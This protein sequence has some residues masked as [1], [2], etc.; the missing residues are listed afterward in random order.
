MKCCVSRFQFQDLESKVR[1]RL[2]ASLSSFLTLFNRVGLLS[3][4][5]EYESL[6]STSKG[7]PPPGI[8]KAFLHIHEFLDQFK[9]L[10]SHPWGGSW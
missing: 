1:H 7:F 9:Y 5:S 2:L 8:Y 10:I 6:F 4:Q 3:S